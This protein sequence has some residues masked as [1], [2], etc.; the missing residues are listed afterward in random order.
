L[1]VA[2]YVFIK[3]MD[4]GLA[5]QAT[6]QEE[7]GARLAGININRIY[8]L[9][10]GIGSACAGFAGALLTPFFYIAPDVGN[11]F[12]MMAFVVVV[13]GGMGSF[14][15]ALVGGLIIG[16]VESLAASFVPGSMK[17]FIIYLIFM[18]VLLVKPTGLFGGK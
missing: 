9:V 15:G 10:F 5:I 13:L 17:V 16:V 7:V 14:S 8:L 4:L 3:K 2:L 18:F 1:T 6:A 12:L 11:I